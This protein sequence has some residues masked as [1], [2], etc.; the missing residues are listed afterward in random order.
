MK[1]E[2]NEVLKDSLWVEKRR[3]IIKRD[4]NK[5]RSCGISV[6]LQVHHK[7]YH[8]IQSLKDFKLPWEYQNKYL[9]TLCDNCHTAGHSKF[10]VPTFII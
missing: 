8:F 2:Y 5:C 3:V 1:T 9:I 6:G 7:Q 4:N 10:K